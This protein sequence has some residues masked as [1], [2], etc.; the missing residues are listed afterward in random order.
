MFINCSVKCPLQISFSLTKRTT[1]TATLLQ[2]LFIHDNKFLTNRHNGSVIHRRKASSL[3]EKHASRFESVSTSSSSSISAV[4]D[5]RTNLEDVISNIQT[6]INTTYTSV[7]SGIEQSIDGLK[8]S[9]DSGVSTLFNYIDIS[10]GQLES[11]LM[12]SSDVFKNNLNKTGSIGVDLLRQTIVKAEDVFYQGA[13][14]V[15]YSYESTKV[16]LP[17]EARNI[18]NGSES[19]LSSVLKPIGSSIQ[20]VIIHCFPHWILVLVG[21]DDY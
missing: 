8:E 6:S 14:F 4:S 21:G 3:F 19:N 2:N 12:V 5:L 9:L 7:E 16:L 20:Q 15:V 10:K 18:L 1:T 11:K 17:V 13:A